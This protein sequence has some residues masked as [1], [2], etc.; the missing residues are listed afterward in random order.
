MGTNYAKTLL[1]SFDPLRS[2]GK[3]TNPND[4]KCIYGDMTLF[5]IKMGKCITKKQFRGNTNM[6]KCFNKY[7][8]LT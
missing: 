1:R 4:I 6:G 2:K 8:G 5:F 7:S 3:C